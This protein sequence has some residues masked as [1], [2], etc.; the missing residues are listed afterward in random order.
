M[1]ERKEDRGFSA[2]VL[3]TESVEHAVRDAKLR[4]YMGAR[5]RLKNARVALHSAIA[6]FEAA[7]HGVEDTRQELDSYLLDQAAAMER[8]GD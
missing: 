7:I 1:T 8:E 6:E 3:K 2:R 4:S 5:Q